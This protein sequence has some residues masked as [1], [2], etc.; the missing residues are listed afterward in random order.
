MNESLPRFFFLIKVFF[1]FVLLPV[2]SKSDVHIRRQSS[3][4]PHNPEKLIFQDF[5]MFSVPAD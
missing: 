4:N 5:R 2:Q 3:E 1:I